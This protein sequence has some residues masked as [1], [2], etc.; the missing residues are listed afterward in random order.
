MKRKGMTSH[1]PTFLLSASVLAFAAVMAFGAN[2]DEANL[3][4]QFN[5]AGMLYDQKQ[6]QKAREIYEE[7]VRS[8]VNDPAVLYNL[9]NACA[10][11]GDVG[12]AVLYYTRALR[13]A[14]RDRD[15]RENLARIQPSINRPN[16]FFLLK[17]FAW[18]KN[19]ISLNEW[20]ILT[21][22]FF[23]LTGTNLAL[24][25]LARGEPRRR[26]LSTLTIAFAVILLFSGVFLSFKAYEE[27][28][29]RTS[30]VMKPEALARSGPGEQ[31]EELYKFPAGTKVRIIS[32]PQGGWVRIRLMDGRSAYL[33]LTDI[34]SVNPY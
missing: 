30:I 15:V 9:G 10:R 32:D 1:A 7:I 14:P 28:V 18:L 17:P 25:M 3:K 34:R 33:P 2:P 31:F 29:I 19:S 22:L 4:A 20:T 13:L 24:Y 27:L 21:S 8:G 26:L 12:A 6:F 23:F 5:R 11:T 16:T